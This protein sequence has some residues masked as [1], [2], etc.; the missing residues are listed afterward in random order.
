VRIRC[1]DFWRDD[2]ELGDGASLLDPAAHAAL[3]EAVD[4]LDGRLV[5][6]LS[7]PS[8][9]EL[10]ASEL[11]LPEQNAPEY[12]PAFLRRFY[13]CFLRVVDA[14]AAEDWTPERACRGEELALWAVIS[15]AKERLVLEGGGTK[16][17]AAAVNERF[18]T[19]EDAAFEDL[20]F[21]WCFDPE[22][23]GF[24]DYGAPTDRV[25]AIGS[26][27]IEDWFRPFSDARVVHP[28]ISGNLPILALGD[29][30][31]LRDDG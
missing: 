26:L 17:A 13:L 27:R 15:V 23:V 25:A 29:E 5:T 30:D 24:G 3:E 18:A 7:A 10:D 1:F 2:P 16:L 6:G 22:E 12:D 21:L 28:L 20:D 19:F 31:R 14:L 8:L 11:G 9:D 4:E